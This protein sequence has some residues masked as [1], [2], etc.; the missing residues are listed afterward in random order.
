MTWQMLSWQA[1]WAACW[2]AP[3]TRS[4]PPSRPST[5]PSSTSLPSACSCGAPTALPSA[6]Q[7]W[8]HLTVSY[9]AGFGEG[10]KKVS[11]NGRCRCC[12]DEAGIW[13]TC[14]VSPCRR[15]V[16]CCLAGPSLREMGRES[17]YA[18]VQRV[19]SLEE[20]QAG[21]S[22]GAS[23][24]A[25]T[26]SSSGSGVGGSSSSSSRR[27]R[28]ARFRGGLGGG[29]GLTVYAAPPPSRIM[30]GSIACWSYT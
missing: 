10:G 4:L 24:G 8:M 25:G 15:A 3:P 2:C 6:M 20:L 12:I 1:T 28:G 13:R 18:F 16:L 27:R 14:Y 11:S 7:R 23:E 29:A 17:S 30:P 22:E 19:P 21:A 9:W 5:S 26:G